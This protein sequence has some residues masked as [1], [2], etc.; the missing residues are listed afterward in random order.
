MVIVTVL[1]IGFFYWAVGANPTGLRIGIV[2]DEI[3]NHQECK[4]SSLLTAYAHDYTCDLNKISCRF[5]DEISDEY[6]DKIYFNN[7]E[8][9]Y[10]QAKK[11]KLKSILHIKSNFTESTYAGLIE[12]VDEFAPE[13]NNQFIDFYV[14]RTDFQL[15][16][17]LERKILQAYDNYSKSLMK[18][19]GFAMKIGSSP[20]V[21][22][23]PIYGNLESNFKLFMAPIFLMVVVFFQSLNSNSSSICDDRKNGLWNRTMLS[24]VTPAEV[25]FSHFFVQLG[26]NTFQILEILVFLS[27]ILETTDIG[28]LSLIAGFLFLLLLAGTGSGMAISCI[29]EDHSKAYNFNNFL[30]NISITVSGKV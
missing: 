26:F 17:F 20:L 5:I 13:R 15:Y 21:L 19:C 6:S 1:N 16:I 25:L 4:N 24:G 29:I 11:G 12:N 30:L 22:E 18:D 8:D 10:K 3:F 27:M 28:K 9:A 23:K 7:F 2:N 14:D